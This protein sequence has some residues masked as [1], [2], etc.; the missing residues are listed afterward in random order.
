VR[1]IDLKTA[2]D[3][4]Y[5]LRHT[6]DAKMLQHLDKGSVNA[7]MCHTS[8]RKEYDHRDPETLLKQ[9]KDVRD[10]IDRNYKR[11]NKE[12]ILMKH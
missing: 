5:S 12:L 4:R 11:G 3:V 9:Y 10:K 6:F 2:K 7:L 8:Y 1:I